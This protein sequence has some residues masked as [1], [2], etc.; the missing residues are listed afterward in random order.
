MASSLGKFENPTKPRVGFSAI[1][2]VASFASQKLRGFSSRGS[3]NFGFV[4][5]LLPRRPEPPANSTNA[6]EKTLRY[7]CAG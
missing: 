3:R 2:E 7:G 6:L 1:S 5:S 4:T